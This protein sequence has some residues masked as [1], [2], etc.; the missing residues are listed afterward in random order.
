MRAVPIAKH[1]ANNSLHLKAFQQ[2]KVLLDLPPPH[3]GLTKNKQLRPAF[4]PLCEGK[5]TYQRKGRKKYNKG[6][7]G[8]DG[9]KSIKRYKK[10]ITP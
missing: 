8:R 5:K 4:L 2:G 10:E 7:N 6:K 3:L 1:F 9:R